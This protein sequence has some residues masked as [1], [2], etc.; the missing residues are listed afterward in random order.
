MYSERVYFRQGG[1]SRLLYFLV[2]LGT[3]VLQ[4]SEGLL[5]PLLL[6]FR[7]SFYTRNSI[8]VLLRKLNFLK[9]EA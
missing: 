4:K 7:L 1:K 5:F 9:D 2:L 3:S 8:L 6:D